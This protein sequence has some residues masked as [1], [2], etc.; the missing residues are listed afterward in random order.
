VDSAGTSYTHDF[1]GQLTAR[2]DQQLEWDSVGRLTAVETSGGSPIATYTYD[3]LDRLR[4]ADYGGSNRIRFRYVGLTTA[5]AQIVADSDGAIRRNVATG[6]DGER[7][8][9]WE[10]GGSNQRFYGTNAHH[11]T[12]WT[13]GPTGSVSATLRYDPWGSLVDSTGANL[14]EWRFQG[15]W[16]DAQSNLSWVVTRWYAPSLGRFVSEDSLLGKP[17]APASRHLYAYVYGSPLAGRDPD[18][19]RVISDGGGTNI[20]GSADPSIKKVNLNWNNPGVRGRLVVSTFVPDKFLSVPGAGTGRGDNRS[21]SNPFAPDCYRTRICADINFGQNTV[22]ITMRPSCGEKFAD[23]RDA[24]PL[25]V[26]PFFDV[27]VAAQRHNAAWVWRSGAS[28]TC[29]RAINV[30][31]SGHQ[32]YVDFPVNPTID[33]GVTVKACKDWPWEGHYKRIKIRTWGDGYP[34]QELY[35]TKNWTAV[36]GIRANPSGLNWGALVAI[37]GD[38]SREMDVPW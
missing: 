23:C 17:E 7:L 36:W 25:Q 38:W 3:A 27:F 15:S 30:Q 35:Y 10:A 14:P 5:V 6:W 26:N 32:S 18:G 21:W 29:S 11:D 13:A 33:G 31:W 19:R 4:I 2:P 34:A 16:A 24:F 9:D 12:T 20:Y 22:K 28:L 8:V 37:V 1:E